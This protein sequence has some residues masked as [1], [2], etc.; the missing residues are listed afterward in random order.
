MRR[1][2]EVGVFA[3]RNS[4]QKLIDLQHKKKW[5]G[6][7][8]GEGRQKMRAKVSEEKEQERKN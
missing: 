2:R 5:Y 7:G 3:N 1:G 4:A 8:G 6:G